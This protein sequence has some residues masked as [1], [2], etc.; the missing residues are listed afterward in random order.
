M[1]PDNFQKIQ[2]LMRSRSE[3]SS[4]LKIIEKPRLR[5]ELEGKLSDID[6]ELEKL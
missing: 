1:K 3:I 6:T 4:R 5:Q 2:E